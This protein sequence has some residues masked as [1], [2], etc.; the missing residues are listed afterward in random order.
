M[1]NEKKTNQSRRVF[2]KSMLA[3]SA[4]VVAQ[5]LD[6]GMISRVLASDSNTIKSYG[7]PV[8]Q[9][10]YSAGQGFPQS[11]ASGDPSPSGAVLWTR[12]DPSVQSGMDGNQ[13]DPQVV[14]WLDQSSTGPNQSVRTAIE[15]G[16]FIMVE[17]A[18]DPQFT[19]L[20]FRCYTP[21]WNDFD[22]V[23]KVD[24]DGHLQPETTFY[25]RF[26]TKSGHVSRTG[27]FKTTVPYGSSLSSLKFG[28]VSCQ[29]Y[30][31]G[32]Y[33]AYSFMADEDLD[34]V[35]HLGDYAY[36][37]ASVEGSLAD[38]QMKFPSGKSKAFTLADYRTIYKTMK[39]DADLQKSHENHAMIS[40]WDDHEFSNDTYYPAMA[41]DDSSDSDPVRRKMANQAWFEYTPARVVL[42]TTKEFDQFKIYRSIQFGN[43]MELIMTDERLYR[44]G[45]PCGDSTTDKFLAQGCPA[46]ND[47]GR[48]MMGAGLNDQR[49]WFLNKIKSSNC[50]WKIWANEVQ[51]TPLKL[52]SRYVA[53]DTWDGFPWERNYITTELKKAGVKNLITITGDLHTFEAGYIK[54]DYQN[55]SDAEAVGVELMVGSVSSANIKDTFEQVIS[56]KQPESISQSSPI[57]DETIKQI[58]SYEPF[59]TQLAAGATASVLA[60]SFEEL[61]LSSNPWLKLFNSSTHGYSIMELTQTKATWTA[62]SV[63]DI[64]SKDRKMKSLLFLCEVP[65]DEARLDILK[66]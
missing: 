38:R 5:S 41:P 19:E 18:L 10:K 57:P 26:I 43:L 7:L 21:I 39:A 49:D 47:P 23:V 1:R 46:M 50:T 35:V 36:E 17:I 65:R 44:S 4:L 58:L 51:F 55:D 64:K 27:K 63:E 29:H 8:F 16:K 22:N 9:A 12:V 24:V 28:Y 66:K 25:Y 42:D 3:G 2:L 15:N 33:H 6:G 20:Q 60:K 53:L 45:P 40:I 30:P 61:I 34:F 37:Y 59:K 32:Y 13:F 62:Y 52:L 14:Q 56:S 11:V 54:S 31:N 48:S